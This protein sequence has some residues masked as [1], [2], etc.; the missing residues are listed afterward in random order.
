MELRLDEIAQKTAGTILQGDPSSTFSS[1]NIDSRSSNPGELFFAIVAQRDGHEFVSDALARGATGA[2]ISRQIATSDPRP[3]LVLV[4]E[5]LEAL[6]SLARRA[7]E[8][9]DTRI[10]GITGSVGKTTT[11]EFL[12]TLLS[13]AFPTYKSSGNFNNHLGLPLSL[14]HLSSQHEW[15]VLEY[16]MNHAGEIRGLTAIAAP[17]IAVITNVKPVHLEFFPDLHAIALAKKEILEGMK[18]DGTAVLNGDDPLVREI[19]QD[20]TGQKIF[21]GISDDAD[22]SARNLQ[23]RGWKG[24]TFE[25]TFGDRSAPISLPFFNRVYLS[26][27]LAAAGA[28]FT[29]GLPMENIQAHAP[30]LTAYDKR[31]QVHILDND[32][33][34]VDDSYNSNPAALSQALESLSRVPGE[35]KVAVLGNMLELGELA[36]DFH[37]QAGKEAAELGIGLLITVGELALEM[38]AGAQAAGLTKE[39]IRSFPDSDTAAEAI[40]PLLDKGDVV[41]I[42]GSRGVGMDRIT[43]KL[44]ERR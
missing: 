10:I 21:F 35:R 25:L 16:G 42:K 38:A 32:I 4:D 13:T 9:L 26:N 28:A 5:T 43:A 33:Y 18:P 31:G 11:K 41:L 19:S 14:L 36:A 2:V 17:D 22:I 15:A 24:M 3:A 29:C 6:Q 23:L 8:D 37:R 39:K 12:H 34:L 44:L 1:Y 27:F 7:S 40:Q 30:K 20:F